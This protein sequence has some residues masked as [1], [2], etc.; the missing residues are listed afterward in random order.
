M[1]ENTTIFEQMLALVPKELFDNLA[2]ICNVNKGVRYFTADKH[3]SALLFAQ[4][5]GLD[6]LRSLVQATT[7][8]KP[9]KRFGALI[10]LCRSTLAETNK[11]ISWQFYQALFFALLTKYKSSVSRHAFKVPGKLFSL[12]SSTIP[13]CLELYPWAQFQT[14]KGALKLHTLLDHDD[15]IPAAIIVTDGKVHDVRVGR[16]MQFNNGDTVLMDRGYFDSTWFNKLCDEGVYFVTRIKDNIGFEW[17]EYRPVDRETGVGK[18]WIG[19]FT[20]LPGTQCP[21]LLR[22]VTYYDKEHKR[23]F[24]FL[25][26]LM[27]VD[28]KEIADLYKARWQ[29]ELF[30]KW[31]KQNL[32]IKTFLG[33]SKNA[34]MIQLWIAMIALLL[35]KVTHKQAN[36]TI[37][38]SKLLTFIKIQVLHEMTISKAWKGFQRTRKKQ[39]K[40]KYT[41]SS[42][43][44]NST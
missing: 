13:L 27:E 25:T 3:F 12:D 2:T 9:S 31:I 4:F 21:R 5:T 43:I 24:E 30:F 28:A 10:P 44:R 41:Q 1:A 23:E 18:D 42:E 29:I 20:G 34:V 39:K 35:L 32:K 33:T 6:S 16:D 26:N 36:D 38:A 22:L 8:I 7:S 17:D 37:T 15:M 19:Q 14:R 11:R 40:H